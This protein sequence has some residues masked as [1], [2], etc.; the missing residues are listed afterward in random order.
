MF[1]VYFLPPTLN[2]FGV[3]VYNL[4][5]LDEKTPLRHL[6]ISPYHCLLPPGFSGM[7]VIL[8]PN[9]KDPFALSYL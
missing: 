1:W 9:K 2:S 7:F 4:N 3:S 5:W 6:K 8:V